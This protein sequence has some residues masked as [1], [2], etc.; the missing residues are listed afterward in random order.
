MNGVGLLALG[1]LSG[2]AGGYD[3]PT[4]VG[5]VVTVA[6]AI[7]VLNLVAD[8]ISAVLDP[9][10]R[11]RESSGLI[12]LPRPLQRAGRLFPV[13]VRVALAGA[14]VAGVVVLYA[15]TGNHARAAVHV[16]QE[17]RKTIRLGWNERAV[18]GPSLRFRVDSVAIGKR[19]WAVRASVRNSSAEAL[20]LVPGRNTS[21]FD[22]GPGL[23]VPVVVATDFRAEFKVVPA[24]ETKP[25]LPKSL[26][27]GE[28][29]TGSFAGVGKLPRKTLINVG[30]GLFR[31]PGDQGSFSWTSQNSFRLS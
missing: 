15:E 20:S 24:L 26:A 19:T 9:R 25:P 1:T 30:F 12:R 6:A 2:N 3:L 5:I 7:V 28:G 21:Q 13:P 27:P 4:V 29:W 22:M 17:P 16:P 31:L 10:I 18:V 14:A 8:I 23:V 11:L